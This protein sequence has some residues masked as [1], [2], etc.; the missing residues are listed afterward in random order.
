MGGE[1]ERV[2]DVEPDDATAHEIKTI[3]LL[4]RAKEQSEKK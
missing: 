4:W 3:L 1:E 2:A